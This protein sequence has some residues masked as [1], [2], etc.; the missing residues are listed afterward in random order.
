VKF[1]GRLWPAQF[2]HSCE[3]PGHS[4]VRNIVSFAKFPGRVAFKAVGRALSYLTKLILGGWA[5]PNLSQSADH[6]RDSV[7][8]LH[9]YDSG[10]CR[11][12][13]CSL[14]QPSCHIWDVGQAYEQIEKS[15]ALRD[16]TYVLERAVATGH[17]LVQVLKGAKAIMGTTHS[18]QRNCHDR[19]VVASQSLKSCIESY[20]NF[21]I[22]R[23]GNKYIKQMRGAPIGGFLSSAI[24][25]LVLAAAEH[26]FDHCVW[27]AL[28]AKMGITGPRAKWFTTSRYED[29][30][31]CISRH[32]CMKC[33][34]SF[35]A[36]VYKSVAVFDVN[37]KH[38][39]QT[40]NHTTNKFLD[41]S[42]S[43]DNLGITIDLYH[44]NAKF[45]ETGLTSDRDKCRFAPPIGMK[46][47][48][49]NYFA[50]NIM[51]RRA[52]WHHIGLTASQA[53]VAAGL[54][55]QRNVMLWVHQTRH[56]KSPPQDQN[57]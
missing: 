41:M 57:M 43:V 31:N 30:L 54:G 46:C 27:P 22:Y 16:L 18:L 50:Q 5:I 42:I 24:L 6:I 23:I 49:I 10:S 45:A 48:L 39:C 21:N 2:V 51:A 13:Q 20:F 33:L 56:H 28:A 9:P 40:L 47:E 52:R 29:D 15:N 3:K 26:R 32:F 34:E 38:L 37:D 12:C 17:G 44:C 1:A 25:G 35:V 53:A 11:C 19:V 36:M 8:T 4:C 55:Y 7:A 14:Q